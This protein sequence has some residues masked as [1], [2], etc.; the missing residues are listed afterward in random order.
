MRYKMEPARISQPNQE[1]VKSLNHALGVLNDAAEAS[2]DEIRTMVNSDYR[3]LKRVLGDLK[4]EVRSAFGEMREAAAESLNNAGQRVVT[5]TKETAQKIDSSV[6]ENPWVYL[7]GTAAAA[8][9][10]GFLAGRRSKE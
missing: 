9:L 10:L 4:P 2:G 7:G 6:H 1:K 3:K 8:T 5:T